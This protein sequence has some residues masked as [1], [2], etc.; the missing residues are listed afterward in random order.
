MRT[1]FRLAFRMLIR[2]PVLSIAVV[3]T[4]GLALA[5]TTVA[6]G[7]VNGVLLAPLPYRQPDRL[8]AIWERNLAHGGTRNVTSPA[9]FF[10]W[11]TDL[12][13]FDGLAAMIG[14]RPR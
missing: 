14:S 1:E 9:N 11:K 13:S 10:T 7:V 8:V 6:F 3:A 12:K 5:A 2:R 4:I